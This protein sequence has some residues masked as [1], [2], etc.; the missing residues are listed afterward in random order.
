MLNFQTNPLSLN[1][2]SKTLDQP[3]A[4]VQ[5]E[6]EVEIPLLGESPTIVEPDAGFSAMAKVIAHHSPVEAVTEVTITEPG[7]VTITPNAGFDATCSVK[8]NI[9]IASG[10]WKLPQGTT[11]F[12]STFTNFD[13]TGIDFSDYTGK[14]G[15]NGLF[16]YCESLKTIGDLN[17]P[18]A[19][20]L[21]YG[22][23]GCSALTTLPVIKAPKLT[24]ANNLFYN[25]QALTNASNISKWDWLDTVEN[26]QN[27]FNS[28]TKLT[29]FPKFTLSNATNTSYLFGSCGIKEMP[30][31]DLPK[32]TNISYMYSNSKIYEGTI[33]AP[34]AIDISGL[35]AGTKITK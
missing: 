1:P 6:K 12:K 16:S 10:G 35:F 32:A 24:S 19:T 9:D 23:Y 11:F 15:E 33:N 25:C 4:K 13:T 21:D 2:T 8:A 34:E 30:I 29:T 22:F 20:D 7:E 28:C 27:M 31:T 5:A 17:F 18:N 26:V 14:T 3:Y